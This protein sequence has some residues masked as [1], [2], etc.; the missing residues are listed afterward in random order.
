MQRRLFLQ[1]IASTLTIHS[2]AL[3]T[4][5]VA[6]AE[7]QSPRLRVL[8][9]NIHH[10]EGRDRQFDYERL[11]RVICDAKP[12]LVALQEVDNAT[13]RS[14]GVDQATRLGELTKM[15]A[16]FGRAMFYSGGQYGEAVLSRFPII[17]SRARVLPFRY[18]Q[19]PRSAL[20]VRVKPGDGLPELL[21]AGTHLCH[22][23]G[24]TRLEQAQQLNALFPATGGPA[25]ILAGD[26]NSRRGRPPMDELLRERW[27]AAPTTRA[28]I[29]YVLMRR[30]DPWRIVES[31]V[32]N[33]RVAS[34]HRPVLVVLEWT[35]P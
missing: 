32:I 26:L 14:Q 17:E 8:T 9:Y 18:G 5:P 11:A 33:E 6:A 4:A 25:V 30:V 22:Q 21:F 13:E 7:P 20:V 27:T 12:D 1:L 31:Q 2:A 19:E 15:H 16:A 35:G 28:P 34:D 29:D 3:V 24:E 10:G 23:S